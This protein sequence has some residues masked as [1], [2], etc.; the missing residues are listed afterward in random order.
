MLIPYNRPLSIK[1]QRELVVKLLAELPPNGEIYR[2][3]GSCPCAGC[4]AAAYATH[5]AEIENH[6]LDP[7]MSALKRRLKRPHAA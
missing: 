5:G 4:C 1:D 2:H 6:F 7:A 3:H